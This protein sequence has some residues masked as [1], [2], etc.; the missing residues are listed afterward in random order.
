[1]LVLGVVAL[2]VAA[3]LLGF[4]TVPKAVAGLGPA[5]ALVGVVVGA[6]LLVALVPRTPISVACGL[7]FGPALGTVTAILTAMV[8]ATAT[9]A[10]GRALGRDLV[11]RQLAHAPGRE[12]LRRAWGRIEWWIAREGVLAVA[13]VR[14]WPLGP[15]GL[16]GYVYGTSGVRV[17]DY[18]LGTVLA[19]TPSAT[20]YAL[21]GAAVGGSGS[22]PLTY[23]LLPFGLLLTAVVAWRTRAHLRAEGATSATRPR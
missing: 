10:V 8:A 12:R 13:T 15:Y 6:A 2:G 17:R 22:S 21:L 20:V 23:L 14:S 16:V 3:A 11:V 7:L 4:D 1:L 19:A 18:A 9:F 5:G